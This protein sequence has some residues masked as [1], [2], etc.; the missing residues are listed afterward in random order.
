MSGTSRFRSQGAASPH[1]SPWVL[2]MGGAYTG[3]AA[4]L[5]LP[6]TGIRGRLLADQVRSEPAPAHRGPRLPRRSRSVAPRRLVDL[7]GTHLA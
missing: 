6:R 7:V 1:L 4:A 3:V 2:V 5:R